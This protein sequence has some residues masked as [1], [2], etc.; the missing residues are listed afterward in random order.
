MFAQVSNLSV[1]G[2]IHV[3]SDAHIYDRHIPIIEQVISNTPFPAPKFIIDNSV[4]DFYA[5]TPDNFILQDY[6]F[7]DLCM[8]I[9]VAI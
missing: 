1:G 7:H 5:F 3:I 2:L 6:F 4:K 8:K 9:P